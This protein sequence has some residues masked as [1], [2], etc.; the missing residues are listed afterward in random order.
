MTALKKKPN[1][2]KCRDNRTISLRAH[3]AKTVARI[4]EE[5]LEGKPRT[6]LQK[7]SWDLVEKKGIKDAIGMLRIISEK[8]MN[9]EEE[10]CVCVCVCVCV[11]LRAR[12]KDW[13]KTF[14]SVNST[15]LMQILKGTGIDRREIV[16]CNCAWIKGL[17]NLYSGYLTKEA[18][19]RFGN[20]K[21]G[22]QVIRNE[23]CRRSRATS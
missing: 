16:S 2:T 7:I 20:F 4:L 10:L 5:G 13:Q 3:T 14:S 17:F 21:I 15:K 8:T 23:I 12:F 1:V 22:R 6:Y 19:E 9:T 11:C 18:I